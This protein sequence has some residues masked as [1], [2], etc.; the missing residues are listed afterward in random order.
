[1]A[2]IYDPL[3]L[4]SPATLLLKLF[5][6]QISQKYQWDTELD[7]TDKIKWEEIVQN[8]KGKAAILNRKVTTE[9]VMKREL[10]IFVD[11]STSAYAVAAYMRE[12]ANEKITCNLVWAKSRLN[13]IKPLTVP[14]LELL[15]ATMGVRAANFL[16]KELKLHFSCCVIWVDSSCVLSWIKA[17]G[18]LLPKFVQNR[19]NEINQSSIG[20]NFHYVPT[21]EN[22][23]DLATRGTTMDKLKENIQWWNG[24]QWLQQEESHWPSQKVEL[25]PVI[26]KE[27]EIE[28]DNNDDSSPEQTQQIQVTA[29]G[30]AT[31]Q[32]EPIVDASRISSWSKLVRVQAYVNRFIKKAALEKMEDIKNQQLKNL[33]NLVVGRY[34]SAEETN[35]A[36]KIVIIQAQKKFPPSA[37]EMKQLKI[38][39]QKEILKCGGRIDNSQLSN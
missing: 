9:M 13:P 27:E 15:A 28:F 1:M 37:D 5:N 25:G 7:E 36:A 18:Q 22:P 35:I 12:T 17:K 16:R 31:D 23:A 38:F 3:G 32:E 14:R 26:Q 30:V 29:V 20:I 6:Q 39:V 4:I 11:A 24:P 10:H 33:T 19:L 34:I 21:K 8:N 2:S